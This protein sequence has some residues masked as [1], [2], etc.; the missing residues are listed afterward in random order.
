M[1]RKLIR[2]SL[3]FFLLF[4]FYLVTYPLSLLVKN[5]QRRLSL[6][7]KLSSY[8][9]RALLRALDIKVDTKLHPRVDN[10]KTY[11]IAANHLSYL[12]I[13]I[14]SSV[15]PSVF[16]ASV[17][18]VKESPVLGK[19]TE[20]SGGVFIERRRK[21]GILKEIDTISGIMSS[22]HNIVLFPEGTTSDGEALL[23]FKTSFFRTPQLSKVD[24]LP[25]CI[26]YTKA[27]GEPL[28]DQ[29]RFSVFFYGKITFF[30]HLFKMLDLRSIDAELTFLEPIK[31]NNYSCRKQIAKEAFTLINKEYQTQTYRIYDYKTKG[32]CEKTYT[33]SSFTKDGFS[34]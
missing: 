29:N 27:D 21:W 16:V 14:I 30:K 23:P 15:L 2:F 4:S 34:Y 32:F 17:D 22:G 1:G 19:I 18:G 13:F 10:D 33:G 25:V 7:T 3:S 11:F 5:K 9:C 12:D 28:S 26:K 24:V 8:W 6:T 31:T 20:L